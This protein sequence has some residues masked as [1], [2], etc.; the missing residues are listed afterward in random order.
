MEIDWFEKLFGF[1]EK[2]YE[3]TKKKLVIK[4]SKIHSL[5]NNQSYQIGKLKLKSLKELRKE[6]N[7]LKREKYLRKK[8]KLE[9]VEGNVQYFL[10]LEDN[11]SALFQVAS[12][13]N[14][15]E[16]IEPS[17]TPEHGVTR[18]RYD[19][20]QGP[21][22]SIATGAATVYRNYFVPNAGIIGQTSEKQL[23]GLAEIQRKISFDLKVEDSNI[24]KMQ[25]GYVLFSEEGISKINNY[26][27]T[28]IN[29]IEKLKENLVI[30]IHQDVEVTDA[31]NF[32]K[33]LVSLALCSAIPVSYNSVNPISL[34]LFSCLILEAA[35]EATF[36]AG[37]LNRNKKGSDKVYLT[38]LG[39]GAFEN[40]R[41]WI[42]SSLEKV[43]FQLEN[44]NLDIKIISYDKPSKQ[45]V[46][47]VE[48]F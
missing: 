25:N 33:N 35:Y 24:W 14:M 11:H 22:C 2:S 3:E 30:G 1:E 37:I 19:K 29:N 7:L 17:I 13:F 21:A 47:L 34:K 42:I 40:D 31:N 41:N 8:N 43:L 16:M 20:T 12:Q 39:G 9:I 18:Y 28:N 26:L 6:T 27:E 5:I 15:L 36:L 4:D 23:N 38:L 46:N 45:L 44:S 10:R 48:K 32:N